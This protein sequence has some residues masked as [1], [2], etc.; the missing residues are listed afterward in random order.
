MKE[1]S[2]CHIVKEKSEFYGHGSKSWCKNCFN[3]Y[4][5]ERWKSRKF[6]AVQLM[7]G[8]CCQCGYSKNL[9]ALDFH[10][11]N[12]SEKESNWGAISKK[13]WNV[14]IQELK[15]C[16]LVCKNCHAEIHHPIMSTKIIANLET[17]AFSSLN[18]ERVTHLQSNAL[19]ERYGLKPTGICAL[20]SCNKSVFAT[21]YCSHE[22]ASFSQRKVARPSK[23][24]LQKQLESD[25]IVK[26]GKRYGVSD[27]SIR[28]WMKA[29][30][31]L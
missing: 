1:C 31:L 24:D 14:V 4:C 26:I 20:N 18:K 25:S 7:G 15:K 27:N 6:E 2:K 28:K 10:H 9:S 19:K 11:V 30:D 29:Y 17:S 12:P 16:I 23:K 21:K 5:H 3:K 22:C 8:C 13:P